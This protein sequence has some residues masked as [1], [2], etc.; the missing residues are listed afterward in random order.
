MS[1][2]DPS[3]LA[4]GCEV[5]I[6]WRIISLLMKV[7]VKPFDASLSARFTAGMTCPWRGTGITMACI[8]LGQ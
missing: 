7:M 3:E 1:F 8:G 2:S 6:L 5:V 4:G